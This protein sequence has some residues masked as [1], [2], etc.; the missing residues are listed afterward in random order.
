[1]DAVDLSSPEWTSDINIVASALKLWFRELPEPLLTF[2]LYQGFVDA[3]SMSMSHLH[4]KV[5][6]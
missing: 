4:F 6:Y 5:D 3:A 2:S 1:V